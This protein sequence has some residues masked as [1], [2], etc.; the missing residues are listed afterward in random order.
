MITRLIRAELAGLRRS[1]VVWLGMLLVVGG[2]VVARLLAWLSNGIGRT[3][4][5]ALPF[6]RPDMRWSDAAIPLAL[7][8]YLVVASYV[9]GRD[10]EDGNIDLVLT[11]PVSREAVVTARMIVTAASVLALSLI[12][13]AADV[14]THA[15]LASSP[16]DPGPGI[17]ASAA[18]A[19]ALA[20]IG[21]LPVVAWAAIRF[22]GVLPAL[23]LGIGIQIT[24]LALG[25]FAFVR[26][27]P[28][29][30]PST[31]AAGEGASL[32]GLGLSALLFAGGL[33]AT[34]RELRAVDLFE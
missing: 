29:L 12:G 18:I 8:A 2:S 16:L 14:A 15:I 10:F 19:S 28:W 34:V 33:V 6:M 23:G 20:A 1:L 3:E 32:L 9:F 11:S 4:L 22:R 24:A 30:L 5:G 25:G 13:W 21:T 7:L 27:L 17:P 31:L 26:F